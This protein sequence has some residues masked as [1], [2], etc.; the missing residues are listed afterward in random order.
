[1]TPRENALETARRYYAAFNAGDRV[2]MLGLLTDDVV[3][4][5]NQGSSEQGLEVFKAFMVRMDRC[6]KEELKDLVLMAD[7]AGTRVAAEFTVH[8]QYLSTDEGLPPATGQR[9]VLPAGAFL[10]IA[11]GKVARVTMYY[12]LQDWCTQVGV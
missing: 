10:S 12:N 11:G 4:D 7:D 6:Y 3:H 5:I 1:M 8:G 2:T 9:Y